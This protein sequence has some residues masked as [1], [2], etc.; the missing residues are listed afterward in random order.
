MVTGTLFTIFILIWCQ[1]ALASFGIQSDETVQLE[2]KGYEGLT[3]KTLFRGELATGIR[4]DVAT[5]YKG[6]AVLHFKQGQVYPIILDKQSFLLKISGPGTMPSFI[7]SDENE[8]FYALLRGSGTGQSQ[9]EFADLMIEAK[10]L[11]D[12]TGSIRR[13]DELQ[14]MKD[15]FHAFVG[16]HYQSLYHSDMLMRLIAQYFMM[17]EYVDYHRDG[18]PAT[19]I[20]HQYHD[21]V[22]DGVRSWLALLSPRISENEVLN[23]IVSLYYNRSM[24]SLASL[25]ISNFP[26]SAYCPGESLDPFVFSD[27]MEVTDGSSAFSM[28]ISSISGNKIV[29]FVAVDCPVSMVATVTM[30]RKLIAQKSDATMIVAPVGALSDKHVAM[31]RMIN[32]GD[33]LFLKDNGWR[34]NQKEPLRL[35]LFQQVK[36]VID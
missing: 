12:S 11:L 35:P 24:V 20:R 10:Q 1:A 4:Q 29:A 21:A 15:K 25:I 26:Q 5:P 34:T 6:L 18:F 7:G 32:G 13:V 33:L 27:D 3:A 31:S 36:N 9:Y 17:H 2:I 28:P 22:L 19:D 23:Y 14:A 8:Y 16:A 30:A